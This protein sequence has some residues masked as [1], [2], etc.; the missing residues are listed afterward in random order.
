MNARQ[1]KMLTK[2]AERK[3]FAPEA[4]LGERVRWAVHTYV[5]GEFQCDAGRVFEMRHTAEEYAK[6]QERRALRENG[7]ENCA[8]VEWQVVAVYG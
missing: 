5:D 4:A 8:G 1:L 6:Q 3:K 2:I 7:P